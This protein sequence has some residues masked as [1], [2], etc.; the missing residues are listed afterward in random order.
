MKKLTATVFTG[1]IFAAGVGVGILGTGH[2]AKKETVKPEP[3]RTLEE[4]MM[5][6]M[7]NDIYPEPQLKTPS[8]TVPISIFPKDYDNYYLSQSTD[9]T[10]SVDALDLD[11]DNQPEYLVYAGS[12]NRNSSH[13]IFQKRNGK[14]Q[15]CG[16][17]SGTYYV[18]VKHNGRTGFFSKYGNGYACATYSYHQLIDG[19]LTEIISF[20]VDGSKKS[21]AGKND[22]MD[23]VLSTKNNFMK[24]QYR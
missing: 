4:K 15:L 6:W 22:E 14:W 11:D 19:K 1:I 17:I 10:F 7:V 3:E 16:E 18:P 21:V 24:Q 5:Y 13:H 20:S 23:I 9:G 8:I 2:F 12:G